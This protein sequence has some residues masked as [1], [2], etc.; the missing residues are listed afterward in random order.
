MSAE[1]AAMLACYFEQIGAVAELIAE[2]VD[3][4]DSTAV[5]ACDA[6]ASL[7]DQAQRVIREGEV[8]R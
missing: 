7:V 5:R 4:R 8:S 3:G 6:I 1:Q 2:R